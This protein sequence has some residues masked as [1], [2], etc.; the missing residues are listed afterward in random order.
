MMRVAGKRR[1]L[2]SSVF[3]PY[4]QDDEYGSRSINPMELWHNQVTRVQGPWS[5]RMFHR[6]YGLMMIRE[7]IDAD[8]ALLDFPSLER[9]EQELADEHYDIVGIT[10]IAPNIGKAAKMC[11]LVRR[12]QPSAEIV[13]GGHVAGIPD[14]EERVDADHIA[15][16]EGIRWF[17]EHLGQDPGASIKHPATYSSFGMR[18]MGLSLPAWLGDT[19]AAVFPSVGCPMGCNFCSTSHMFGGK[20]KF[21]NFFDA[22]ELFE[23]FCDLESKLHVSQFML[24]DENFLLHAKRARRLLELMEK[25]GKAWSFMC[26]ASAQ[27][28]TK[29]YTME[30]LV[31]FGLQW[32]WIGLEGEESQYKKLRGIDTK[33]LVRRL[34]AEGIMVLGSTILGLEEH[35]PDNIR[36]AIRHA[37]DHDTDFHQFMLYTPNPGTPLWAEHKR[38]GTLL[39]E[40]EC[41]QADA[42]G[43]LKFKHRHPNF[44]NGEETALIIEAFNEDFQ[45][46]GPSLVRMGRTLARGWAK[47]KN[48]AD[49]RIRRR[50]KAQTDRVWAFY[51]A[52]AWAARK[53]FRH[54]PALMD[55]ASDILRFIYAVFGLKARLTAPTLGPILYRTLRQEQK[56]LSKGWTY[57]PKT[58]Y[59]PAPPRRTEFRSPAPDNRRVPARI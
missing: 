42:H 35:S 55:E 3:G 23:V 47:Y 29:V 50:Y 37:V 59:E 46:N 2:L 58:I 31:R 9:F 32:V 48:H 6:S 22:D 28:L 17:R 16:G 41:S 57:E 27:I 25:H 33:A 8:C 30:E 45:T 43:Q 54:D 51:G 21:V 56:R 44:R 14:L 20:G 24:M 10:A 26:F 38:N 39:S 53:Y 4:A 49:D 15:R 40:E 34:Q 36:N 13:V 19:T 1:I 5:L 11:E 52:V 12:H 18:A 7:N